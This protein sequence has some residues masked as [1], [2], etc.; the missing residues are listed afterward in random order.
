[1]DGSDAEPRPPSTV[2]LHPGPPSPVYEPDEDGADF[3]LTP[4]ASEDDAEEEETHPT[5]LRGEAA[6]TEGEAPATRPTEGEA[7]ATRGEAPSTRKTIYKQENRFMTDDRQQVQRA[8]TLAGAQDTRGRYLRTRSPEPLPRHL[9]EDSDD[10]HFSIGTCNLADIE[11]ERAQRNHNV[12]MAPVTILCLQEAT[13]LMIDHVLEYDFGLYQGWRPMKIGYNI[14]DWK[15]L[16]A[17]YPA[18]AG[19]R[20]LYIIAQAAL[21]ESITVVAPPYMIGDFPMQLVTHVQFNRKLSGC[22]EIVIMNCH[23]RNNIAKKRGDRR[24]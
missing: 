14:P 15:E 1:M 11:T 4:V 5:R 17:D 22:R 24:S 2:Q 18:L 20:G 9:Y 7:L 6:P 21:T 23:W 19:Y 10:G 12:G 8:Q 3:D 13:T 16:F